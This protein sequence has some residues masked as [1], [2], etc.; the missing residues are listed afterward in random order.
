MTKEIDLLKTSVENVAKNQ[1]AIT[2]NQ[3]K[4]A[5]YLLEII[6]QGHMITAESDKCTIYQINQTDFHI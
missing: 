2:A 4:I 6:I 5:R 1:E 3:Q